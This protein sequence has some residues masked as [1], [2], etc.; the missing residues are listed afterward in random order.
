[1]PRPECRP[2][3][4]LCLLLVLSP[5]LMAWGRN[6]L[7][8]TSSSTDAAG[9]VHVRDFNPDVPWCVQVLKFDRARTDFELHSTLAR[10]QILGLSTLHRQIADLPQEWGQPVAGINADFYVADQGAY[11]GDPRGLQILEGEVVSTPTDGASFWIDPSGQPRIGHVTS[12]FRVTWPDGSSTPIGLN[13]EQGRAS[14]V[15]Y[16]PRLG[17]STRNSG[18]GFELVLEPAGE[19][20]WLPLQMG[21]TYS[22]KVR[23]RR[24]GSGTPLKAGFL[25]LSVGPALANNS[26]SPILAEQGTIVRI[27][28]ATTPDLSGVKTAISGG[29]VLV[30]DGQKVPV[31]MPQTL[32]YKYRSMF[33]RH[34]RT[35]IGANDRTVFFIQVDGRQPRLSMGMTLNELGDYMF[36]LGCTQA[37]C[38]DGGASSTFWY[39]GKV[40]NSPC[41]GRERDIAN[42]LVLI[43]KG[44][45]PT[46]SEDRRPS[47]S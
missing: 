9:Y 6:D 18:G 11:I 42:G 30:R 47:G 20:P 13:E 28:T 4:L 8:P 24:L 10:N 32:A 19:G 2:V 3:L 17:E 34:P 37:L 38:L 41:H 1:M 14:A 39:N 40:L 43:Q 25:V 26:A 16:T 33:E 5:A 45:R 35:A 12:Q 44:K 22:A 21:R 36:K 46:A 27:S 15:L 29:E 23:E 31:K 7:A